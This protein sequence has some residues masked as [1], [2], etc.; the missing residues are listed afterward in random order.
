MSLIET[1]VER[2]AKKSP[3][4]QLPK[5]PKRIFVL[6]NNDIGDLLIVTPLFE[7]LKRRF[8]KATLT[9]GVGDWNRPVLENN[10]YVDEVV[11]VNAPWFN[12]VIQSHPW[13]PW[14]YLCG[15]P[16]IAAL[17]QKKF[18]LGI[19][20]LGS[21]FGALL[22]IKSGIGCRLGV[23]G[24]SGGHT[25][26]QWCVNYNPKEQVGR[27]ALRFAE[28]LGL[29]QLPE[30]RPQIFLT[31]DELQKGQD[32]W[33]KVTN[34]KPLK[35]VLLGP[36]TGH[37]KK[38]WPHD[39]FHE[40]A[41]LLSQDSI[42]MV[43]T[44]SPADQVIGRRLQFTCEDVTGQM[45]LRETFALTA[46]ADY[47]ICNSS[48]LLHAAAAFFKPTLV[49]LGEAYDSAACHFAQWGTD[50]PE[51]HLGK[52]PGKHDSLY[53]AKEV[54][55]FIKQQSWFNVSLKNTRQ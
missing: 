20:V 49:L 18:D 35:R 50:H 47:V 37:K 16:E 25:A 42:K 52:E 38:G 33:R 28:Y 22:L 54:A 21:A 11:S 51:W 24:Y 41:G 12:K 1:I 53:T 8:P 6:R 29:T 43:T 2:A 5:D 26:M 46:A 44:G 4:S 17:R 34:G 31:C 39:S 27:S 7:A 19:D 36:G 45:S 40:L 48:M 14:L 30:T 10:P 15:S 23:K 55:A 3:A 32:F 9:V 13:S